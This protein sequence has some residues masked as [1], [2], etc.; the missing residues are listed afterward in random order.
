MI[1][2]SSQEGYEGNLGIMKVPR[3]E[4]TLE[5]AGEVMIRKSSQEGYEGDLGTLDT[6][7]LK[8]SLV[9][10]DTVSSSRFQSKQPTLPSTSAATVLCPPSISGSTA[11][12]R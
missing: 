5:A 11:G 8:G 12:N 1:R 4:G 9:R 10:E 2:I 6:R 7:S 3:S